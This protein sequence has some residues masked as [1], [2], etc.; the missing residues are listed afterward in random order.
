MRLQRTKNAGRNIFFGSL[1]KIYQITVPFVLRTVMIY[2]LG[3]EYVGLNSLFVSILQVLNLAELGVGSAMIFSMYKPIAENDEKT[4]CA[5]MRLYQKYYRIIGAVVLL[6][7]LAV[8]PILT[9]LIKGDIPEGLNLYILYF[10]NLAATVLTYWLFAYKNS[11][12]V[13]HQRNDVSSKIGL[14]VAT[15]E[16]IFEFIALIFFRSY[17]FYLVTKLV[18]Q[19]IQNI[20]ISIVARKMFPQYRPK[21]ELPVSVVNDINGKVKDLFTAKIGGVIVN[22]ADSIVISAFLGLSVLAIYN[23]YY[24]I[25]SS[26]IGFVAIIFNSCLAGIGNS[27]EMESPEKNYQDFRVFTL[28]IVWFAGFCTCCLVCLYQPFMLVWLNDTSVMFGMAEVVCLCIYFFVY[29]LAAMMIQYKDAAGIWHEDR[30]RPLITAVSNLIMN[31]IT[32]HFIGIIGVLLSTVISFVVIGIP[33]LVYNIFHLLFHRRPTEYIKKLAFYVIVT[34]MACMICY[35][36]CQEIFLS[37]WLGLIVR[38]LICC[39]IPNLI[40]GISYF[41]LEEFTFA[42]RIIIRLINKA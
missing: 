40:F 33:W 27:L 11:I 14:G 34:S 23:N 1:L 9:L 22:S 4:I 38:G 10:L 36:V 24:Y 16:Y 17:Y 25:L 37:G 28:I 18:T 32:V 3:I 21:G 2:Y 31:L 12:L 20:L 35:M 7:G 15:I 13:A 30:F 39:I 6:G 5:L 26:I 41:K 8:T 42:K 19:I 29:E